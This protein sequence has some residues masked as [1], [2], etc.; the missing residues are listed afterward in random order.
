MT[1][2]VKRKQMDICD[3]LPECGTGGTTG[4]ERETGSE[5]P[6]TPDVEVALVR[7]PRKWGPITE[8]EVFWLHWLRD[9]EVRRWLD[10][11]DAESET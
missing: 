1:Q 10:T 5:E 9:E 3:F 4:G 11:D 8:P 7:D 6:S 2:R